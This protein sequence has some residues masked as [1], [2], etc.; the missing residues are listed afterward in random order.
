MAVVARSCTLKVN[1]KSFKRLLPWVW[2][3]DEVIIFY[4][5]SSSDQQHQCLSRFFMVKLMEDGGHTNNKHA[6]KFDHLLGIE[7]AI[8][9]LKIL[10]IPI[11]IDNNHWAVVMVF[12]KKKLIQYYDSMGAKVKDKGKEYVKAKLE[13]LRHQHDILDTLPYASLLKGVELSISAK[14]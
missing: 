5:S 12:V 11:Y 13:Y 3:N 7:K 8:T 6:S 10:A 14:F 2:L 4:L 1:L 9:S